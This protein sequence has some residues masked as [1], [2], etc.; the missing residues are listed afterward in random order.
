M[1]EL[2]TTED[3][4]YAYSEITAVSMELQYDKQAKSY[5]EVIADFVTLTR[6]RIQLL[7]Y[8]APQGAV[9]FS[10]NYHYLH[11]ETLFRLV[12]EVPA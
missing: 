11:Q 1:Q 4:E 8:S 2:F 5:D 6:R 10:H 12:E 9:S 3:C 7:L